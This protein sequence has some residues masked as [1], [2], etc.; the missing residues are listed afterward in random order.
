M[1]RMLKD[2]KG[3]S[4]RAISI[5][6]VFAILS[7]TIFMNAI[8][9]GVTNYDKTLSGEESKSFGEI[10]KTLGDIDEHGK[11][12]SSKVE[13]LSEPSASTIF[14]IPAAIID[15]VLITFKYVKVFWNLYTE[16]N[17]TLGIPGYVRT[18]I[19]I[20][21]AFLISYL[22]IDMYMRYKKT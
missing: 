11:D 16:F 7:I 15:A 10:N 9:N 6:L 1:K 2:K 18:A 4:L 20:S 3:M 13:S 17:K 12:F 8:F 5:L 21:L 14:F 22:I 19:E